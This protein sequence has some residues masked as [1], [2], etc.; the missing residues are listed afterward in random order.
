MNWHLLQS[1]QWLTLIYT[2]ELISC[3]PVAIFKNITNKSM[4]KFRATLL[5]SASLAKA[6]QLLVLLGNTDLSLCLPACDAGG[7]KSKSRRF[8]RRSQAPVLR[9]PTSTTSFAPR[10]TTTWCRHAQTPRT[11]PSCARRPTL[12]QVTTTTWAAG[13]QRVDLSRLPA[14]KAAS[15]TLTW[16]TWA[17]A[18]AAPSTTPAWAARGRGTWP[19][20][21]WV[22]R[23]RGS[24]ATGVLAAARRRASTTAPAATWTTDCTTAAWGEAATSMTPKLGQEVTRWGR[25]CITRMSPVA[26]RTLSRPAW[27]TTE[28]RNPTR[29]IWIATSAASRSVAKGGTSM[30]RTGWAGITTDSPQ[31]SLC[32]CIVRRRQV[33]LKKKFCCIYIQA[34]F[35]T[36]VGHW[37]KVP[38]MASVASSLTSSICAQDYKKKQDH[39]PK[40][41][42]QF[43][44]VIFVTTARC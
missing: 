23:G 17:S 21:L 1:N 44:E 36:Q 26:R 39:N 5:S 30:N 11:P 9:P 31:K 20:A 13:T 7:R 19:P 27:V 3:K 43:R 10:R 4:H 12:R 35:G 8:A 37:E 25:I 28:T 29:P 14:R 42:H 6:K 40:C 38:P 32:L 18:V 24:F 22:A 2:V 16:T 34:A 15:W 33:E 41:Q